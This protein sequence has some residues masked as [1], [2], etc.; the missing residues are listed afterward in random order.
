MDYPE[1]TEDAVTM[2][3]VVDEVLSDIEF[4]TLAK[5]LKNAELIDA[6][7]EMENITLS[8]LPVTAL[9]NCQRKKLPI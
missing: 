7:Q 4:S 2:K 5:S 8:P 6:L 9:K 3:N 1:K